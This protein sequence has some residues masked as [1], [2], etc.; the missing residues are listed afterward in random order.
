MNK[1]VAFGIAAVA[2]C[3]LCATTA[4]AQVVYTYS[5]VVAPAPVVTY[6]VPTTVY[7]SPAPT[8]VQYAPAP[9]VT[10]RPVAP[11]VTFRPVMPV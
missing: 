11:V 4:S 9:V 7:Y 5:P 3:C 8:V 6:S 2:L 10:Y 1:V